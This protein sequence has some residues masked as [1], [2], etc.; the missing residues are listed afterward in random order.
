MGLALPLPCNSQISLIELSSRFIYSHSL[1]ST[2][3]DMYAMISL[4]LHLI[5]YMIRRVNLVPR[6]RFRYYYV[7]SSMMSIHPKG[8]CRCLTGCPPRDIPNVVSFG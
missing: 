8:G 4:Y 5:P 3:S 7:C 1:Y 6:Q 2:V